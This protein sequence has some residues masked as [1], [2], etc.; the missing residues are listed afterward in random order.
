MQ[1]IWIENYPK[2]CCTEKQ[3][4]HGVCEPAVKLIIACHGQ[5]QQVRPGEENEGM[6]ALR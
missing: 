3:E 2:S 5:S 4:K 6:H 1:V